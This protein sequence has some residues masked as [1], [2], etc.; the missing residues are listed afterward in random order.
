MSTALLLPILAG[1]LLHW[2]TRMN[3]EGLALGVLVAF[4]YT[5]TV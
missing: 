3:L 1:T 4:F 2:P 5:V